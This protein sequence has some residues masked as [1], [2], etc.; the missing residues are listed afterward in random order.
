M[1][2]TQRLIGDVSA[3]MQ[4]LKFSLLTLGCFATLF[5]RSRAARDKITL[6]LV[7]QLLRCFVMCQRPPLFYF[8][9]TCCSLTL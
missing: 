8:V 4:L 3:F 5:Y 2:K 1:V 9:L 7:L 6:A